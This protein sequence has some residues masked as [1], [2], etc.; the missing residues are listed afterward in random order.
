MNREKWIGHLAIFATAILFG[1]NI[2][3]AKSLMPDY[4]APTTVTSLRMVFAAVAFW[5]TSLFLPKE[6]V[7]NKDLFFLFRASL[8]GVFLNQSSFIIGLSTTS[9]IDASIIGTTAPLIVMII[10]AIFLKEPITIK[11]ASGVAIGLGAAIYIVLTQQQPNGE[12]ISS[13]LVGNLLCLVG[14]ALYAIY[15]VMTKNISS[16]YSSVTI[17]KWMFL[18][19]ST[20]ILPFTWNDII[21]SPAFLNRAPIEEYLSL[22]YV[23]FC[24]TY[25]TYMLIPVGLKR[26]RPTTVG[27]YNYLQPLVASM[28]AIMIG[29]DRFTWDKPLAGAVI[30][31]GV[32]LVTMSKSKDDLA[33]EASLK[34][35]L[36]FV[37]LQIKNKTL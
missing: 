28:V 31:I 2:P 33:R 14:S 15:L 6:K 23:L 17:M 26:I 8:F 21:T 5:I 27:M 16:R 29:Q 19:A 13:S 35:E 18:F 24:A 34:R 20:L 36:K 22:G 10:A 1:L 4:F 9:P 12:E 32:Y 30:F 25:L 11:K 7:S 37:P 3:I